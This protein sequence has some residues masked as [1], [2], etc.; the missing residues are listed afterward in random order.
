MQANHPLLKNQAFVNGQWIHSTNEQTFPVLNPA[1]GETI[2]NVANCGIPETINAI[3]AA[4]EAGFH[5][6]NQTAGQRAERL[7]Q[8]H[9]LILEN[10]ADLAHIMTLEQGKPLPEATG[11]VKYGASFIDW[12]AAE[13]QRVYGDIIPP[14]APHLRILVSKQPVGVVGAITPWNFPI[15]MITRKVAPALAAG[16]TVVLKPSEET[17]LSALALCELARQAGIPPGVLNI[18]TGTDAENIGKT[19]ISSNLVR[20]ISF[21]GSTKVGKHLMQQCADT[22]KK[23]SLELGGNA[24]F[25]V[26]DDADLDA[27]V[28]GAILSKFRNA[29][30]T[31][32]C[33][34]RIYAQKNIYAEFLEKFTRAAANQK[35]GNGL[36]QDVQIGPLI[37]AKATH[38]VER[39]IADAVTKGARILAGGKPIHT[40]LYPPTII[41]DVKPNMD[42]NHEE[43]FGPVA[44]ISM[45]ETEAEII[46]TANN[47]PYGLASY[48]YTKDVGRVFRVSEAL[49]YG[50][51]GINTGIIGTAVAPFGGMKESGLGREG[52]KYGID[53]FLEIKYTCLAGLQ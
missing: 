30:Q 39:L 44:P 13:G 12:F 52:S 38:K 34:N 41:A 29:G 2:T 47:T 18:I 31:C 51:V 27:A 14:H 15:A 19:L 11:E 35:A 33:A 25:I 7:N 45:F 24:P 4:H 40:N 16:C 5:W 26:F 32:V 20:K 3:Q 10:T 21:T 17:P 53:D 1:T 9:N 28:E 42:I 8:W 36:D 23:I 22:V 49:D 48:F 37:N 46:S 43:I 50:I 6:K